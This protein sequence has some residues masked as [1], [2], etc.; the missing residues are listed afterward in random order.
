MVSMDPVGDIVGESP[1]HQRVLRDVRLVAPTRASVVLHGE[2]GTG[3]ELIAELI[4]RESG[5]QGRMVA[6]NCAALPETLVDSLLFGHRRGAF[7]GAIEASDGLIASADGG[8][9]F[10]DE[11]AELAPAVQA[12]LL[13]VLQQR[14]VLAVG[15]FRERSVD[16]RVVAA[17]HRDLHAAVVDGGFRED[18]F[19]RLA[20]F[21]I[22][23]PPLR[24]RGR[25]VI[26]I[27]RH[28][29]AHEPEL[30]GN[31]RLTR[32]AEAE[33]VRYAWP[34]NVRELQNVLFRAALR[35]GP[36]ITLH[37]LRSVLGDPP[38]EPK[39]NV[40]W[41]LDL[42]EA[43]GSLSSAELAIE[44]H[45]PRSTLQRLLRTLVE[46]GDLVSFGRGKATRYRCSEHRSSR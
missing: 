36:V 37:A 45:I 4:H 16:V 6:V 17:S 11:V 30:R 19:F 26:L 43:A 40:E 5:R 33:L 1:A 20:K 42:V 32:M 14:T 44:G 31:V 15:G 12:K 8:T 28:Y 24:E 3:K 38:S 9:L 27:A 46:G 34:G 25:D 2:S 23:L 10:L 18:L 21:E 22:A 39:R 29:L 13:R 7:T 35:T 41:I